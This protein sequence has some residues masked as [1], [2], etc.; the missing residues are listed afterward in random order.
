MYKVPQSIKYQAENATIAGGG[1]LDP[2]LRWRGCRK[3]LGIGG[4][5][6]AISAAIGLRQCPYGYSWCSAD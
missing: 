6:A 1:R 3:S 5:M 2:L 4:L